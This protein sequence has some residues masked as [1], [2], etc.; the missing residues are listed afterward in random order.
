M[1]LFP[2]SHTYIPGPDYAKHKSAG[3]SLA[4]GVKVVNGSKYSVGSV[5]MILCK[6]HVTYPILTLFP[7]IIL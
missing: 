4:E 3:M 6:F 1:I 5:G 2:Y 7:F